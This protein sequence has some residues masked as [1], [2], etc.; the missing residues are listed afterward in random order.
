MDN[1]THF[2]T[3]ISHTKQDLLGADYQARTIQLGVGKV[4]TLVHYLP[5]KTA[6]KNDSSKKTAI[7]YIHGYTDYFFQTGLAEFLYQL[8]YEFYALDLH[9]YGRSMRPNQRPNYCKSLLDYHPDIAAAFDLM[10]AD[11]I[12]KCIPLAH[13]TGGLMITSYLR[14]HAK[15]HKKDA[16]KTEKHP[17]EITGLMLNSPFLA[18]IMS[19]KKEPYILPLYRFLTKSL[20]FLN[21]KNWKITYYTQS[22]HKTLSG[23]WEY[24]LDWKPALGFP[25]SFRWLNQI[26]AEQARCAK[27]KIDFPT[28][29]CRSKRSTYMAKNL[30]DCRLGDGVLNVENMEIKVKQIYPNLSVSIFENGFHDIYLSA[31]NVRESYLETIKTW[32]KENNL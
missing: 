23:E 21:I 32:L 20:S 24:R 17:I 1:Q 30:N 18:M 2:K 12:R 15:W 31:Q 28:L 14:L 10:A 4:C 25:L 13:S 5:Q 26:M 11:G 16:P 19:P 27:S 7:L 29:L 9:G 8:G 22:L 3:M 6:S